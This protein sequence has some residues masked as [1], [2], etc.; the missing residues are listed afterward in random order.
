M[1]P[2]SF[3]RRKKKV[4]EKKKEK[5][6]PESTEKSLLE[7]L[8]KGDA[9]LFS[10]LSHTVLLDPFRLLDEGL[11]SYVERAQE[12]EEKKDFER[13]RVQYRAAG[14]IALYEGNLAQ[15]QKFFKKCAELESN[16]E[17]QKIFAYFTKKANAEKALKVAQEYYAQTVKS[18]E[19]KET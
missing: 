5:K 2:P 10:V 9:E 16:P 17:F 18:P 14:E 8:C 3:F 4:E 11:S 13:A 6:T 19:G 15:V 1:G 7:E 12:F